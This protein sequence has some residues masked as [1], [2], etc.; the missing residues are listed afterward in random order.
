MTS[1]IRFLIL[2]GLVAG[3]LSISALAQT[4]TVIPDTEAAQNV[5]QHITVEGVVV[6]V[7]T[8]KSG[9]TFLNFGGRY[10]AQTFTRLDPGRYPAGIRSVSTVVPGQ[11][12]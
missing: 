11:E 6:K 12:N 8:S 2:V 7:F 10:P 1:V 4:L 9:N 5:G 3:S